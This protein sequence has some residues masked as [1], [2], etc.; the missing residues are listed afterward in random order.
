MGRTKAKSPWLSYGISIL[1][2]K[3]FMWT[4]YSAEKQN[5]NL[6]SKLSPYSRRHQKK[7]HFHSE[8]FSIFKSY[9]RH[10]ERPFSTI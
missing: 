9:F 4:N 1:T 10:Q 5:K 8:V 3:V 6:G 7:L 2:V